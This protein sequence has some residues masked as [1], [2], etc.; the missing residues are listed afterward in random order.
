MPEKINNLNNMKK[1]TYKALK[2]IMDA[3]NRNSVVYEEDMKQVNSW[4]DEVAEDYKDE[5]DEE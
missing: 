4:I 5:G 2:R 3:V 1:E